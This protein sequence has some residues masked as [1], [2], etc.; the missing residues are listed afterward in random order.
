M[1]IKR[2][3]VNERSQ[4]S[5]HGALTLKELAFYHSFTLFLSFL[6]CKSGNLFDQMLTYLS[7]SPIAWSAIENKNHVKAVRNK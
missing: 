6:F 3:Q 7:F 5:G 1:V 2:S 4:K